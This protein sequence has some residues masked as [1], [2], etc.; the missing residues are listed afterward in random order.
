M[1]EKGETTVR[2][3]ERMRE[4]IS[5]CSRVDG[6]KDEGKNRKKVLRMVMMMMKEETRVEF[7]P[8]LL[9]FHTSSSL[10]SLFYSFLRLSFRSFPSVAQIYS[11]IHFVLHECLFLLLL[12]WSQRVLRVQSI[13][14]VI[15]FTMLTSFLP[16]SDS[17]S[18][19]NSLS[20][21]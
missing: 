3:I 5:E 4:R 11:F 15:L 9:L 6:R 10:F 1:S 21:G 16:C 8:F 20:R 19:S 13:F 2:E 7:V 18:P 14:V 12:G 17:L